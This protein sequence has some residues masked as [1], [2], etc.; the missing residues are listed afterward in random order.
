[1]K[2][3]WLI[4]FSLGLLAVVIAAILSSGR[5]ERD[6][7]VT[8]LYSTQ[9]IYWHQVHLGYSR[10]PEDWSSHEEAVFRFANRGKYDYMISEAAI[11]VEQNSAWVP[12]HQAK[13]RWMIEAPLLGT[14]QARSSNTLYV[15]AP[16]L[17]TTSAWRCRV[18]G[19]R[20]P[21]Y[22]R[23][24]RVAVDVLN[25]LGLHNRTN[26]VHFELVSGSI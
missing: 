13:P 1:M 21:R 8:F 4:A 23:L 18:T 12:A 24:Q 26:F 25:R 19:V 9:A 10:I 3:R 11:E 6:V 2:S 22:G 14:V 15:V 20:I 16:A 17:P 7:S 5:S